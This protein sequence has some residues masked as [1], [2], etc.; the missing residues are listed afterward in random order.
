MDRDGDGVA[1][2]PTHC[3]AAFFRHVVVLVPGTAAVV[4]MLALV[5]LHLRQWRV[6]G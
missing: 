2:I 1:D 5:M 6:Q 3:G 4:A